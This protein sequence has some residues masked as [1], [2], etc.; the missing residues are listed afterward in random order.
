MTEK[1]SIAEN[2][3]ES[4]QALGRLRILRQEITTIAELNAAYREAGDVSVADLQAN[5]QRRERLR[6]IVEEL[7][8]MQI[9]KSPA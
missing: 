1:L 4:E 9:G 2:E 7:R 5:E 3:Q 8:S 6:E